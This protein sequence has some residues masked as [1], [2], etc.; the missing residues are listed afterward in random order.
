LSVVIL[1]LI[2]LVSPGYSTILFHDPFPSLFIVLLGPAVLSIKRGM[3][4]IGQ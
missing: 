1:V 4:V 2:N 3:S